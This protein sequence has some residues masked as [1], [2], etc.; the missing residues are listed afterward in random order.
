LGERYEKDREQFLKVWQEFGAGDKEGVSSGFD[1][2]D[3]TGVGEFSMTARDVLQSKW[4]DQ[5][6]HAGSRP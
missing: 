3:L 4:H 6:R 2:K 5:L 1:N